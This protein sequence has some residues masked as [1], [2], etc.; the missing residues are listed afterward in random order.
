M[1]KYNLTAPLILTLS[2]LIIAPILMPLLLI[3]VSPY[4]SHFIQIL[5]ALIFIL[6]CLSDFFDGYL[7]RKWQQESI[8]GK[9]LDPIADKFL[10]F[11]TLVGL[12]VINRIFFLWAIIFIGRE[13]F[14]MG[15]RI[16]A[17]EN[18]VRIDVSSFG[19]AKTGVQMLYLTMLILKPLWIENY[20]WTVFETILLSAA[21][22][23]T[24][25]SAYFYLRKFL[26]EV[27]LRI[28]EGTFN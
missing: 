19:K 14:I 2:R 22:I 11:S 13:F 16:L 27:N 23:L 26:K 17:L 21:L 9:V 6:F 18:K 7:A 28:Y 4:V 5:I 12:L 24:L 25:G 10:L 20:W 3:Y 1:K 8:L 15:L